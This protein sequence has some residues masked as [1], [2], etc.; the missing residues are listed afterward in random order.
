M[1]SEKT[2][3]MLID[4]LRSIKKSENDP[5]LL[6]K[7]GPYISLRDKKRLEGMTTGFP[8]YT[9]STKHYSKRKYKEKK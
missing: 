6:E 2:A 9:P 5:P 3:E 4:I 8:H 7:Y 1:V